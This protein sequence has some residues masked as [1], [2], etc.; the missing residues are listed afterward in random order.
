MSLGTSDM[1][2]RTGSAPERALTREDLG[3]RE[4]VM[5]REDFTL[6][7]CFTEDQLRRLRKGFKTEVAAEWSWF[8]EGD[9]LY[10]CRNQ[11]TALLIYRIDLDLQTWCHQ[12]TMV[13]NMKMYMRAEQAFLGRWFDLRVPQ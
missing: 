10:L 12:V 2:Q 6:Q 13:R 7:Y 9:T 3:I 1:E 11:P 4:Y 5:P 8:M